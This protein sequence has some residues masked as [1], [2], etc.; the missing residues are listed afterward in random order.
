MEVNFFPSLPP[1]FPHLRLVRQI[2]EKVSKSP[3]ATAF[4][5]G[6][7]GPRVLE[8]SIK[9]AAFDVIVAQDGFASYDRGKGIADAVLDALI[10]ALQQK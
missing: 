7:I 9:A 3:E 8:L 2:F 1:A 4:R 10:L 6:L 5:E